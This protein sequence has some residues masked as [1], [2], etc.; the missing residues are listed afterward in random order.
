MQNSIKIALGNFDCFC[1][2]CFVWEFVA[3]MDHTWAFVC[4]FCC[5]VTADGFYFLNILLQI[6]RKK[7]ENLTYII[8]SL[9][10]I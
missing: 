4:L 3:L 5:N 6:R 7:T 2:A 8:L 9:I 10:H 1:R